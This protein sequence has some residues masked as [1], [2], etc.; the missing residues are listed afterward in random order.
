MVGKKVVGALIVLAVA[1]TGAARAEA[2]GVTTHT[3]MAVRAVPQ[4]SD[5]ALRALLEAN[6]RQLESGAHFPDSGYGNA[7]EVGITYPAPGEVDVPS[8]GWD[9]AT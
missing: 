6:I 2:S 9:R 4:V 3:W 1:L 8:T 5:P 7:T